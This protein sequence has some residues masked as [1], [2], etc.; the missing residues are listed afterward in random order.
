M[1][2][3]IDIPDELMQ[4]CMALSETK[5]KREAVI[6]SLKEYIRKKQLEQLAAAKG[7]FTMKDNWYEFRHQR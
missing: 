4:A 6:T 5:S 2:T 7:K 3:T 1:R